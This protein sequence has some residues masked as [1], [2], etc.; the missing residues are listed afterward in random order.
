MKPL[1]ISCQPVYNGNRAQ[2]VKNRS[3]NEQTDVALLLSLRLNSGDRDFV[4]LFLLLNTE[5]LGGRSL[6]FCV[7][8]E[9]IEVHHDNTSR[10]LTKH[11]S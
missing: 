11:N 7:L 4:Y 2:E 1:S 6:Y 9:V 10:F 3:S 8:S 5:Y